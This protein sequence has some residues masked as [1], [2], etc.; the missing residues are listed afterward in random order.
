MKYCRLLLFLSVLPLTS[1]GFS[2]PYY[3][4]PD[5]PAEEV[6][7]PYHRYY[8]YRTRYENSTV[9]EPYDDEP[10]WPGREDGDFVDEYFSM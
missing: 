8:P 9:Y 3:F 6:Y 2:S 1:C 5:A 7:D 4:D 10:T